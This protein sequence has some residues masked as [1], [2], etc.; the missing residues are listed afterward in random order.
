MEGIYRLIDDQGRGGEVEGIFTADSDDIE[1]IMNTSV[2]FGEILGKHSNVEVFL[3][4]KTLQLVTDV[5][6]V[7][8]N[9]QKYNMETGYNP[10]NYIYDDEEE[11]NSDKVQMIDIIGFDCDICEQGVY[12][13]VP[14]PY[15]SEED[16]V[17]CNKCG[18]AT[19]RLR[20]ED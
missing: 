14:T 13:S 20:E 12:E 10:F 2:Y 19:N 15:N 16:T 7:V 3:D 18:W 4:D 6:S 8:R 11:D 17:R 9:F 5:P 1:R